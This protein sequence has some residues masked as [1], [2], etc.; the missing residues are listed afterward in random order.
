MSVLIDTSVWSLALRRQRRDLSS[1]E[2][3]L[4]FRC[5]DL[6]IAGEACLIGPIL[7]ETLSG[8]SAPEAFQQVKT[9]LVCVREVSITAGTFILAAEFF[10]TCRRHG[11]TPEAIDMTI[12]AG[13]H[14]HGAPI[15][16]TDPDFP[17]YARHLPIAL[18]AWAKL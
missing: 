2:K 15:F 18:Y 9:R 14:L 7:Q 13:A 11:I 5:R 16:T 3:S 4:V 6:T 12:C 17:R 1:L 8:I 10:N